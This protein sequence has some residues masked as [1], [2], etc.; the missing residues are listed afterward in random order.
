MKDFKDYTAEDFKEVYD[1]NVP[2]IDFNKKV[3]V[4]LLKT[5]I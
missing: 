1:C 4:S 5:R 2:P 3:F